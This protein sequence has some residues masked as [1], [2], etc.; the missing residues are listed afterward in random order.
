MAKGEV[1]TV[2]TFNDF[3]IST[4]TVIPGAIHGRLE[5]SN[6]IATLVG[7]GQGL[8][9]DGFTTFEVWFPDE[10]EPRGW[11][12]KETINTELFKRSIKWIEVKGPK[13]I[14]V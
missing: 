2:K 12:D 8:Y 6:G 1:D 4:H 9:G 14:G 11:T 5:L 13:N 7:G 10:E 3:K